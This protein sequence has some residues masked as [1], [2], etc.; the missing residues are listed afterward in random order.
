ML[1]LTQVFS[2]EQSSPTMLECGKN[3]LEQEAFGS[4]MQGTPVVESPAASAAD[5]TSAAGGAGT[6][7]ASEV[8]KAGTSVPPACDNPPRKNI[9]LPPKPIH[10][11][12]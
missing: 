10:F 9:V 11:G 8:D 5:M 12:H 4:K 7:A 1:L 3:A 6:T 2:Y